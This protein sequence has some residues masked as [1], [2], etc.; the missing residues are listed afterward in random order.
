[1]HSVRCAGV[2]SNR[3]AS[4][5]DVMHKIGASAEDLEWS[6]HNGFETA[7][8]LQHVG[9]VNIPKGGAVESLWHELQGRPSG[10]VVSIVQERKHT[11]QAAVVK[12]LQKRVMQRLWLPN[13]GNAGQ[14]NQPLSWKTNS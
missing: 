10:M 9:A 6:T 14:Q 7:S 11:Q 2:E 4:L 5:V 3:D 8:D 12:N 13:S 1:M